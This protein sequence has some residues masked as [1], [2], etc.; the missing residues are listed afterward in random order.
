MNKNLPTVNQAMDK[1]N[2]SLHNSPLGEK[3]TLGNSQL[4]QY[5]KLFNSFIIG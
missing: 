5:I 1:K 2:K 4:F 3:E